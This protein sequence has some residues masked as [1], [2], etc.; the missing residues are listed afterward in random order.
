MTGPY[1]FV[2]D[3]DTDLPFASTP[4]RRV[5]GAMRSDI[6]P[7]LENRL[8]IKA[9]AESHG[10]DLFN[11]V[12]IRPDAADPTWPLRQAFITSGAVAIVTP[13]VTHLYDLERIQELC[14]LIICASTT[15]QS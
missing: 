1:A 9:C 10:Y 8:A 11:I 7:Y 2:P 4:R 6:G 12:E 5:V 3:D 14:D 13:D 15:G